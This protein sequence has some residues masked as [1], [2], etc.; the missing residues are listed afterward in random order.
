[1]PLRVIRLFYTSTIVG[2]SLSTEADGSTDA[3][4]WFELSEVRTL[5]RVPFLDQMLE[6]ILGH[7]RVG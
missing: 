5:P 7:A 4:Q 2:G 1:M 3:V 6:A